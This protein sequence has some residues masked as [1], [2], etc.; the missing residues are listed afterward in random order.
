MKPEDNQLQWVLSNRLMDF[1]MSISEPIERLNHQLLRAWPYVVHL[2]SHFSEFGKPPMSDSKHELP[3]YNGVWKKHRQK[4]IRAPKLLWCKLV[5]QPMSIPISLS[6]TVLVSV[7]TQRNP[8]SF[9][10][11]CSHS[12][13]SHPKE[14]CGAKDCARCGWSCSEV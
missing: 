6:H 2:S 5:R 11:T 7:E 1:W 13:I 9:D 8:R 3:I 10:S 12:G 14:T 4:W